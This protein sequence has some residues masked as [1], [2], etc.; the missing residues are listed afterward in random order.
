MAAALREAS[1]LLFVL[2]LGWLILWSSDGLP[3][4][5]Q[6]DWDWA[7]GLGWTWPWDWE[8]PWTSPAPPSDPPSPAPSVSGLRIGDRVPESPSVPP[9][10]PAPPASGAATTTGFLSSTRGARGEGSRCGALPLRRPRRDPRLTLDP[11][12]P[13]Q[14]SSYMDARLRDDLRLA[15]E[16]DGG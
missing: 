14:V 15:C 3:S 9:Q 10:A 8:W 11:L 6:M 5:A 4:G 13:V 7:R 16:L 12:S 2:A 1:F